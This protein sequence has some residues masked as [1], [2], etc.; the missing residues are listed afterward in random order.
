[1]C[2]R[3]RRVRALC[4]GRS[5]GAAPDL[6]FRCFSQFRIVSSSGRFRSRPPTGAAFYCAFVLAHIAAAVL[7]TSCALAAEEEPRSSGFCPPVLQRHPSPAAAESPL[8]CRL[9]LRSVVS[10]L[11]SKSCCLVTSALTL[12]LLQNASARWWRPG[13]WSGLRPPSQDPSYRR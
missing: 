11:S 9:Y 6:P 13:G 12:L 5:V 7:C 3:P 4:G 8:L 2:R 1:M 10:T